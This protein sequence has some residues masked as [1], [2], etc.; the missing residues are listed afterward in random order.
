MTTLRGNPFKT[1]VHVIGLQRDH[2]AR[3][4]HPGDVP[5]EHQHERNRRQEKLSHNV[6]RVPGRHA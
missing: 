2:G 4:R 1:A 6:D 5:E 3:S